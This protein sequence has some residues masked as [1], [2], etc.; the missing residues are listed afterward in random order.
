MLVHNVSPP[1]DGGGPPLEFS[2]SARRRKQRP[3]GHE[4]LSRERRLR[5]APEDGDDGDAVVLFGGAA[6]ALQR[7]RVGG[8]RAHC[9]R[10]GRGFECAWPHLGSPSWRVCPG[11]SAAIRTRRRARRRPAPRR[12]SQDR[13]P[14][15]SVHGAALLVRHR[16]RENGRRAPAAP[17][18]LKKKRSFLPRKSTALK[19][20]TG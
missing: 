4:N 19:A 13:R 12:R 5:R 14:T 16:K 18:P 11:A 7:Q 17:P 10:I 3:H 15:S 8:G 1:F 9:F 2:S 6:W 20:N